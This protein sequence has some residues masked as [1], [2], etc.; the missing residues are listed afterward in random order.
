MGT[1]KKEWFPISLEDLRTVS[2]KDRPNKIEV[3]NLGRP[4]RPGRPLSAFLETLPDVLAGR[5][6][7]TAVSAISRA[8]SNNNVIILGTGAHPI[9]VGLSSIL[10]HAVQK[11]YFTAIACNG[12]F[13]IHDVEMALVGGTSEDVALRLQRGE[14]GVARETAEFI[15]EAISWAHRCGGMGL[16]EAVGKRLIMERVPYLDLSVIAQAVLGSVPVTVHVAIGTDVIHMHPATDGAALGALSYRDFR[17]F[18]RIVAGLKNGVY[19]NLG[20][21]VVLPEVFLKAVNVAINLGYCLDGL[22]TIN[23]DFREQYRTRVNVVERPVAGRGQGIQLIGHH[24][25]MFPLLMAA[26][27]E[28]LQKKESEVTSPP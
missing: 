10:I 16:G 25:L 23:M 7:R 20:S 15:H 26:V 24:E 6:F 4:W 17:L 22:T 19:I 12:A 14:F 28:E 8:I 18:C 9:K 2:L 13:A 11:G 5:S 27:A 3:N 1:D 21:A